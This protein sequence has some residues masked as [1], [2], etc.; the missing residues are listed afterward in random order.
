M[1]KKT[2]RI[3][4]NMKRVFKKT[5]KRH[6]NFQVKNADAKKTHLRRKLKNI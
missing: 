1:K 5:D 4:K 2:E 3:E 6:W